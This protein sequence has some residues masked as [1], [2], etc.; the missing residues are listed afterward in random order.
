VKQKQKEI[1]SKYFFIILQQT[2]EIIQ[3]SSR[4]LFS[5]YM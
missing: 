2:Q 5:F 1:R 3:V 4:L